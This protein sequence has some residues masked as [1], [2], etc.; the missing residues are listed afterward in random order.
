[1]VLGM[2]YEQQTL[3]KCGDG[4]ARRLR[5]F[6]RSKCGVQTFFKVRDTK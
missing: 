6:D 5:G 3:H 4:S 1:M 2:N